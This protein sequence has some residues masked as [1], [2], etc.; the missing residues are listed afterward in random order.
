MTV[1][2]TRYH[3]RRLLLLL[4]VSEFIIYFFYQLFIL[5]HSEIQLDF[6]LKEMNTLY[7]TEKLCAV[8]LK[9]ELKMYIIQGDP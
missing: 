4:K 9:M 8:G 1:F 3:D 7:S 5:I 6:K 2:C